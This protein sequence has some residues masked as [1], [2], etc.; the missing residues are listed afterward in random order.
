MAKENLTSKP[1]AFDDFAGDSTA[2]I[3]RRVF[4]LVE[5]RSREGR[6]W[7]WRSIR[8]KRLGSLAVRTVAYVAAV[9]GSAA[10]IIAAVRPTA[11]E[12][13]FITQ[14]GVACLVLAGVVLLADRLFGWSSGWLRYV[15]TVL[16]MERLT[17]QFR[18]DWA[19]Y[20]LLKDP[21]ALTKEDAR[22]LFD[23]ARRFQYG[24]DERIKEE[25]DGWVAEFNSGMAAL[26]QM[27]R[28][29]R[30]ASEKAALLAREAAEAKNGKALPGA[31]EVHVVQVNKPA[32]PVALE[33]A[34]NGT[35]RHDTTFT[36]P[37]WAKTDLPPGIYTVRAIVGHGTIEMI[38]S[39]RVV[40]V[41]GGSLSKIELT[42]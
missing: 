18:M 7:Y 11:D 31:I 23:L 17:Q 2:D 20:L 35:T 26:D 42:L 21:G 8:G 4:E 10:P 13:L 41:Q 22:A 12:R 9:G 37:S 28:V 29:Q 15:S 33:L 36:G 3:A 30:E 25:T 19:A 40:T 14:I 38:E 1:I 27:I 32:R 6:D 34:S 16:A 24:L 5:T 39:M